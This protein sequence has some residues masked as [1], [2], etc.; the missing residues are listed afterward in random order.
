MDVVVGNWKKACHGDVVAT[1]DVSVYLPLKMLFGCKKVN[2]MVYNQNGISDIFEKNALLVLAERPRRALSSC[3]I[4]IA[5]SYL[6]TKMWS[7]QFWDKCT[8]LHFYLA[9]MV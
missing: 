2:S 6:L 7:I 1:C 5:K 4:G 8:F 9:R 3:Q